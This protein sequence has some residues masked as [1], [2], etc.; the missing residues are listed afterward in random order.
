M[1]RSSLTSAAK[2]TARQALRTAPSPAVSYSGALASSS[3]S[4][5]VAA[6][7]SQPWLRIRHYSEQSS[8]TASGSKGS[9]KDADNKASSEN[10]AAEDEDTGAIKKLQE[11]FEKT[12]KELARMKV[13]SA[14]ISLPHLCIYTH[15]GIIADIA[16]YA[17]CSSLPNQRT[18]GGEVWRI[19]KTCKRLHNVKSREQKTMPSNHLQR[20]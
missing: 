6:A 7:R 8:S 1:I 11:D 18:I 9:A 14:A 4:L 5:G 19:S 12:D 2:S 10:A 13:S 17:T 3:S 16:T 15:N 20:I